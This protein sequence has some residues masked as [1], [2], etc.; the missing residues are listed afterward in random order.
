MLNRKHWL[1][2]SEYGA[3]G[4]ELI[5]TAMVYTYHA[6]LYSLCI[7]VCDIRTD[8]NNPRSP[9][10]SLYRCRN[11]SQYQRLHVETH[12]HLQRNRKEK[13]VMQR[14]ATLSSAVGGSVEPH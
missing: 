9:E 3:C 13:N 5:Y 4:F 10:R 12:V 6:K 14:F 1:R 11:Q 7:A 8:I 2:I